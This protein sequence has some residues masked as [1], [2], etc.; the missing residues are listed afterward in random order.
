MKRLT[1]RLNHTL[2]LLIE[3]ITV[4][5][6]SAVRARG[7][8]AIHYRTIRSVDVCKQFASFALGTGNAQMKYVKQKGK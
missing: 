2:C 5:M 1:V 8:P 3:V 4:V 7:D 6:K